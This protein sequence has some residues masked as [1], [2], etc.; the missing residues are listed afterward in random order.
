MSDPFVHLGVFVHGRQ[1]YYAVAAEGH[2]QKLDHIGKIEFNFDLVPVIVKRD[3]EPYGRVIDVIDQLVKTH[4][5]SVF[6]CLVPSPLETWSILPKSVYDQP[7]ERE[8]YLKI[9]MHGE[10]RNRLETY[11]HDLTNRDFRFLCIRNRNLTDGFTQLGDPCS[12]TELC[13]EFELGV[14]WLTAIESADSIKTIGCYSNYITVTSN[15]MGG[16]RASTY[17]RFRDSS[18]LP[19]L[20]LQ[21]ASTMGWMNGMHDTIYMY[22]TNVFEVSEALRHVL[23]SSSR[24]KRF[25]SLKSM[26][27]SAPEE[28]YGFNLEEAF[29]AI[30][31]AL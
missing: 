15:I 8:S 12:A 21:N 22:G 30:V 5:V 25:D 20:W 27:L 9:L 19:Y 6:R 2:E 1:L 31:L 7:S 24:K 23:D 29:P 16:L 13:S 3:P 26:Q 17:I 11:W 4:R 18:N 28:T 10:P 14:K